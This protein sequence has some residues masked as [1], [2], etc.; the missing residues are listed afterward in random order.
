MVCLS[1]N[2]QDKPLIQATACLPPPGLLQTAQ[3]RADEGQHRA[4]GDLLHP[5]DQDVC[6]PSPGTREPGS[7]ASSLGL[8]ISTRTA[9]R[10]RALTAS[11]SEAIEDSS[12]RSTFLFCSVRADVN[13]QPTCPGQQKGTQVPDMGFRHSHKER[14]DPVKHSPPFLCLQ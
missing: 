11:G 3:H 7:C 1:E 4:V 6:P 10:N 8:A 2:L 9:P 5:G 12:A 13:P 14:R